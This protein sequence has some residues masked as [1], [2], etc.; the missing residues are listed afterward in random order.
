ML[1]L[2]IK[3]VAQ[4]K[5]LSL[6]K[7]SQ[8]SEVSYTIVKALYR[9]PYRSTSTYTLDRLAQTLGVPTTDLFEDVSTEQAEAEKA[10][11]A[12]HR[13]RDDEA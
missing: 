7:L 9:D 13:G 4:Q 11:I 2:R 1:R 5:G 12:R 8:R 10:T 6:N 3:E